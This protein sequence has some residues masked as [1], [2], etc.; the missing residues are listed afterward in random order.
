MA[1]KHGLGRGLEA[2]IKDSSTPQPPPSAG[3]EG[4]VRR[5]PLQQIRKNTFQPRHDFEPTA[6][7]ELV[8]SVRQHGILQPLLVRPAATG[9]ELI[10]GERRLRAATEAGL[11]DVPVVVMQ[12]ADGQ[13]LELALVEN[14]QRKDL[15]VIEEAEGYQLLAERFG[16]TQEQIAVRVGKARASVANAL[17]L[18]ALPAEV[19]A[20]IVSGQL[21]S[22]HAKA[23]LGIEVDDERI[24]LA[25]RVVDEGIP[26]RQLEK[27]V[28]RA[29]RVPRKARASRSDIPQDHLKYLCDRMHAHFGTS[30]RLTPCRTYA[31]GKKGKGLIEIDYYSNDDLDRILSVLG[32]AGE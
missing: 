30:V 29:K 22:G 4:G 16:L 31:N 19:K 5:I 10:A 11:P 18:L 2:L 26:V 24:R 8:E 21:S 7:A 14:L 1:A 12:A 27:L 32:I 15:N 17:R 13:A 20:L 25:R 9:F 23:I 28:E 6:M 3:P